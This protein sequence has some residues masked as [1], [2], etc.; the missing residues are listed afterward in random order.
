MQYDIGLPSERTRE[1]GRRCEPKNGAT[2]IC[3][4][5]GPG[6]RWGDLDNLGSYIY[7]YIY[8]YNNQA[9]I[10]YTSITHFIVGR[11][12]SVGSNAPPWSAPPPSLMCSRVLI[13]VADPYARNSL[14]LEIDPLLD[15]LAFRSPSLFPSKNFSRGETLV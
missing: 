12:R 3:T 10:C 11:S 1:D 9:I 15:Y 4:G 8:T 2:I 7:I 14:K 13:F 6:G 5:R